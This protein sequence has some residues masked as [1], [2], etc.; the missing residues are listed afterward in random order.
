MLLKTLSLARAL[1]LMQEKKAHMA[2]VVDEYGDTQGVLTLEDILETLLGQEIVDESDQVEDMQK[3]ALKKWQER[4]KAL[5]YS[6]D[7]EPD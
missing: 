2:L 7:K 1:Q 5:G 3:E 6:L 4:A